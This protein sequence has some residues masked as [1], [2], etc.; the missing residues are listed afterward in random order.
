MDVDV[1]LECPI[2]SDA[3]GPAEGVVLP[4]GHVFCHEC[5]QRWEGECS[6][7]AT[8]PLC[9]Q[10]FRPDEKKGSASVFRQVIQ[11][12]VDANSDIV[13]KEI[14][15]TKADGDEAWRPISRYTDWSKVKKIKTKAATF[16]RGAAYKDFVQVVSEKREQGVSHFTIR[17]MNL[18]FARNIFDSIA[19]IEASL[20]R[21][22]IAPTM[23]R[24]P[25][26]QSLMNVHI[27]EPR[28]WTYEVGRHGRSSRYVGP[29]DEIDE[30]Q[31]AVGIHEL[32]AQQYQDE[33]AEACGGCQSVDGCVLM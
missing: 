17:V 18:V 12:Q 30:A 23:A 2:C 3:P 19:K 11:A 15:F 9:R 20:S 27:S 33:H 25:P 14:E 16:F 1:D 32:A 24:M 10:R 21:L 8:C 7:R 4:C 22:S 28:H 31:D 26:P 6:G 5:I 13:R 29:Q